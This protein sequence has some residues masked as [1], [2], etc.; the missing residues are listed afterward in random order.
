MRRYHWKKRSRSCRSLGVAVWLLALF[1]PHLGAV[2]SWSSSAGKGVLGFS[3][4]TVTITPPSKRR[5][6][7][8]RPGFLHATIAKGDLDFELDE[9]LQI[10]DLKVGKEIGSGSYGR[11]HE[12]TVTT[13]SGKDDKSTTATVIGKQAWTASHFEAKD[14][15]AVTTKTGSKDKQTP[16]DR[17]KRCDYYW[18]VEEHVVSKLASSTIHNHQI[19]N[20]L[21]SHEGWMLFD[22]LGKDDEIAP[23]LSDLMKLDRDDDPLHLTNIGRSLHKSSAS[24]TLD[25]ILEELLTVLNHIHTQN[26]VHR[27]IKPGNLLIH[28]GT[29]VLIDFGSAADL[30]PSPKKKGGIFGYSQQQRVGLED[31][32]RVAISP[33]YCAPEVYID[34][35]DH[36]C[37]FDLFSAG[38]LFCQLLFGYLDE[39]M[40]AGFHEQLKE[41]NWDINIW[42]AQELASKLRPQ[43]LPTAL[44]YLADRP[45]LWSLLE[46]M[47]S[48]QP[49]LRPTA[50]EALCHLR[51]ILP[52]HTDA[53]SSE[54]PL[55]DGPFFQMVIESM[56]SCIIPTV[57]RALHYV[58]VFD[59]KRPL[60]LVLAEVEQD[61]ED[62]DSNGDEELLWIEATKD[63]LPGEVFVKEIVGGGQAD[64]LGV[65]DVGDRLCGVGELP[66]VTGGFEKAV[67]MIQDQPR[68]SKTVKLLFDRISV[69][70]NEAIPMTPKAD[71]E[72]TVVDSGAWSSKGQRLA[73]ED[74][75][76]KSIPYSRNDES[77]LKILDQIWTNDI[78]CWNLLCSVLHEIHD[79]KDRSVLLAGVFDGHGG[80]AA[81]KMLAE[82]LP[83][84]VTKELLFNREGTKI[85]LERSWEAVCSEYRQQCLDEESC[86]ADYNPLE[87]ILMASTS[88]DDLI[89]GST[90]SVMALDETTGKLKV[91]NCGDSRSLLVDQK[92]QVVYA[93]MDHKPDVEVERF[94]KGIDE[95]LDY[96]LPECSISRWWVRVGEYEYSLSRSLEGPFAASKGI[97]SDADVDVLQVEE[98]MIMISA[99]DGLW[100]VMDSEEVGLDL[101]NMRKRKITARDAARELCRLALDKDTSDN[102]SAV[103]VFL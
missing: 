98:G 67:E 29:L 96:S 55:E 8:H 58:A 13:I 46:Q 99:S 57:S 3:S 63:A 37:A 52:K 94:Q 78:F 11:V 75:F 68:R 48:D 82:R 97:I 45:G 88:S 49:S 5:R 34:P 39:R 77:R 102:V 66:F 20:Y 51:R 15:K 31:S 69:R 44:E 103:V 91:L 86:L 54:E 32:N 24:E 22:R 87:G 47:L 92:G 33:I 6:S 84:I 83:D 19:P 25:L 74:A 12:L 40:D 36:P 2:V 71:V 65:F 70:S 10:S 101:H 30:E 9:D 41:C 18:Q 56:E 89:P 62:E 79:A 50:G 38:L 100:D 73:Q 27:D 42:L 26:I 93:T 90:A 95:G 80:S 76:G 28:D 17:A 60:G 23:S 4:S 53:N 43:G 61:N 35:K 14:D 16:K 64:A 1:H 21:G 81:S 59:R 72:I 85:A 7:I